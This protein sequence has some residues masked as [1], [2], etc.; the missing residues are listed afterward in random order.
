MLKNDSWE[1]WKKEKW[2]PLSPYCAVLDYAIWDHVAGVACQES[3]PNVDT[4]KEH[5]NQAWFNMDG[6]FV[7][8]FLQ[9]IGA[10]YGAWW[11]LH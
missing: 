9:T 1:L 11:W 3:A 8:Q 4:L 5:V 6:N 7:R 10:T 2:L